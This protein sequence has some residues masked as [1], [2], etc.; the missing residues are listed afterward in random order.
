MIQ[1][2][3]CMIGSFAVGKTSLVARFVKS[4]F[5]EK[6][7]TTVGAKIDKKM[8]RLGNEELT[9][10]LWDLHGDDEFQKVRTSYLQGSAGYLLVADGTRRVTLDKALLLQKE[11]EEALGK[12]PFVLT[13]NKSDLAREWEINEGT[14]KQLEGYGW[15]VIRTSA[16]DGQGVEEAFLSLAG[17]LLE[18]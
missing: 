17:K 16:K 10:I 9:L 15:I 12:V 13:L 6:Y 18:G 5:S 7:L 4:I 8:V 3:V 11:A 1:K 14:I 2:K